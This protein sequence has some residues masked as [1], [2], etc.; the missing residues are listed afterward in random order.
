MKIMLGSDPEL[1]IINGRGS[2]RCAD[3]LIPGTK[4]EPHRVEGG[5]VQ[6]DGFAAEIGVD[7]CSTKEEWISR[8]RQVIRQLQ[9]MLPERYRLVATP[10]AKFTEHHFRQQSEEARQLGCEPD[11]NAYTLSEN[12][13]PEGAGERPFRT[14]GGHVHISFCQGADVKDPAHIQR[15]ATLVKQLDFFLGQASVLW[16]SDGDRRAV[17]G[18]AG[19]FRPKSY[20]LEYRTLSNQWLRTD[21]LMS[22][23]YDLSHHAVDRLLAGDRPFAGQEDP[24]QSRINTSHRYACYATTLNTGLSAG[25]LDTLHKLYNGRVD[26]SKEVLDVA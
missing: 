8:H 11:L 16:D 21:Q 19:A 7:P 4:K 15:C 23:V 25:V 5:T 20:G 14:A 9:G 13:V 2:F 12:K 24:L 18:R 22:L 17:Y 3:G 26:I 10:K 6:V 1:F